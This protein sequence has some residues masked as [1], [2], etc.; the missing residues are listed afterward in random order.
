ML[1]SKYINHYERN[2]ISIIKE[3]VSD[4][5]ILNILTKYKIDKE[6]FIKR[7]AFGFLDYHI[8]LLKTQNKI[9]NSILILDFLKYLKKHNIKLNELYIIYKHFSNAFDN[10]LFT[11]ENPSKELLSQTNDLFEQ[12]FSNILEDYTKNLEQFKEALSKSTNIVDNNIIL[13]RWDL[14]GNIIKVSSA[15]CK[16]TGYEREEIIGKS[17]T[18]L[19]SSQTSEKLY[20]DLWNTIQKGKIWK[21]EIKNIT[22]NGDYYWVETSIHPNFDSSGNIIHYDVISQD[23]TSKKNLQSQQ[24]ILIEQ[25]KSAAMGEMISMIAH[26]WRQPLQAVSILVQKLS[27]TKAF[28]GE[29]SDEIME[30]VVDNI[31]SQLDYM[32][33]TIDDF[34]NYFKPNKEKK[35]V[36]IKDVI[37]GAVDF[38]DYMFKAEEIDVQVDIPQNE[39]IYLFSNE[40]V[41]V[42]INVFKNSRDAMIERNTKNRKIFIKTILEEHFINITIE[43]NAGGIDENIISKVFEPYFSTKVNKNG[44]G[45]GLYMSKS[46]IEQHCG[47]Q[48]L[49]ENTSIGT[50]I[51]ISLPKK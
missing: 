2:K 30:E 37:T 31:L 24:D 39:K 6:I 17:Y 26:Q 32:S 49:V 44:T 8:Q 23:I 34:R 11:F 41:Q 45:L 10:F 25:S 15:F 21:G 36:F 4:E 47:G 28:D 12:V 19:E 13:S 7:Y 33:K 51:I 16:I 3:W 50:K 43:D 1:L 20:E 40:I 14:E 46:I 22:K 9:Q 38:L 42:L 29:I 18:I 35:S 27:I 48:I 5:K